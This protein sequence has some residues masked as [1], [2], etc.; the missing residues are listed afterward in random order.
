MRTVDEWV[1]KDDDARPPPRVRIRIFERHSG[2]CHLSGRK[3]RPGEKWEVEHVLAIALGGENRESNLA[4][5]LVAPHK[6]KTAQDRKQKARNDRV[7]K[8]HLGIRK[9]SKMAGSRDSKWKRKMNGQV[10]LRDAQ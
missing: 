10:V 9:P 6:A 2:I 7:R 3:I 5:A 4:P 8:R 1:G